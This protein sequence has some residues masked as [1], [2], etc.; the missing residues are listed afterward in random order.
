MLPVKE[1]CHEHSASCH[2]RSCRRGRPMPVKRAAAPSIERRPQ[3]PERGALQHALGGRTQRRGLC[4]CLLLLVATFSREQ[5]RDRLQMR[6]RSEARAAAGWDRAPDVK[7]C[8]G[9]VCDGDSRKTVS[10]GRRA[11][12]HIPPATGAMHALY[13]C[14]HGRVIYLYTGAGK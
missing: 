13:V 11:R 6:A 8:L 14:A 10:P 4:C 3:E 7:W 5:Q 2:R 9:M 1:N 12:H